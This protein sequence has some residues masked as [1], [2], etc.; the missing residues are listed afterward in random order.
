MNFTQAIASGFQNYV[1]FTG[2]AARSEFW[3]W[4]LF[5]VLMTMAA[6]IIDVALFPTAAASP[7]NSLVSLALFL[8]SLAVSVRRL[9]DLDRS[10]WWVLLV[11]VILI[12]WIV[13]IVWNCTRGTLGPNRFGPDPLAGFTP[14][15]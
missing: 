15:G 4:T 11:F 12:G 6:S 14:P 8:P 2:R 1:N 13:L 9:H 3:L 7:I 5:S 10:G